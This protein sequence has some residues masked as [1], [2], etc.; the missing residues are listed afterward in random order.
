M[1]IKLT[2]ICTPKQWKTISTEEL[3]A[4]GY[5]VYGANGIIGYYDE[6]ND[7][8]S[9]VTITCRGATS[10][11]VNITIPKSYIN[12]NAM[13]LDNLSPE[14]LLKYLYYWIIGNSCES[15]QQLLNNI[16]Y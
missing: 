10:G 16:E 12:G 4:E 14:I 5:P 13:C 9:V 6:Y 1:K 15:I 11:T 8:N 7:E 3:L 2:D